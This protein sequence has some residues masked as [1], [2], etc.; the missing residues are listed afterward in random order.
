[1]QPA[2]LLAELGDELMRNAENDAVLSAYQRALTYRDGLMIGLLARRPFRLK[3]VTALTLEAS[4]VLE[5]ETGNDRRLD[6]RG[7]P[8]AHG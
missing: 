1:M 5:D 4:L 2:H 7:Y 6:P 8:E 3:D